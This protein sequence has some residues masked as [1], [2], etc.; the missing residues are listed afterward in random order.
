MVKTADTACVYDSCK[1][2]IC[3]DS[4]AIART[5]ACQ[6]GQGLHLITT[7]MSKPNATHVRSIGLVQGQHC[8]C[9]MY[10]CKLMCPSGTCAH[11]SLSFIKAR[12]SPRQHSE[13]HGIEFCMEC[14]DVT[15]TWHN[16]A[17][18]CWATYI[19]DA[20]CSSVAYSWRIMI[21]VDMHACTYR[22]CVRQ[23]TKLYG[24]HNSCMSCI[25]PKQAGP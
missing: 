6:V 14:S 5:V 12:K 22:L 3:R 21:K 10:T 13:D 19:T 23:M 25:E 11:S 8:H 4:V 15:V 18:P 17:C 16:L 9:S 20:H 7:C 24:M 2:Q 1:A